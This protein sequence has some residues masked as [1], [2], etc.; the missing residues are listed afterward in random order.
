MGG[1][2]LKALA[3]ASFRGHEAIIQLLLDKR[4]D[5][6]GHAR[7]AALSGGRDTSLKLLLENLKGTDSNSQGGYHGNARAAAVS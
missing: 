4:T 2:R 1:L 7:A 6:H 5:V 3:S